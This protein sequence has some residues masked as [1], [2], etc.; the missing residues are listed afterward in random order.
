M[1]KHL[2]TILKKKR[3][4]NFID[5]IKK[6]EFRHTSKEIGE[7]FGQYFTALY[8]AG[9]PILSEIDTLELDRPIT[10]EEI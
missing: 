2:A 3:D 8:S 5:K 6:G 7:V 9:L 4:I 10:E 1:G